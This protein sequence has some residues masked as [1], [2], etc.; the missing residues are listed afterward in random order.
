MNKDLTLMLVNVACALFALASM[1]LT[2]V[3]LH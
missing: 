1:I 2:I 3:A